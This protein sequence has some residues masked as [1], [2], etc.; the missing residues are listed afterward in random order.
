MLLVLRLLSQTSDDTDRLLTWKDAPDAMDFDE[1]KKNYNERVGGRRNTNIYSEICEGLKSGNIDQMMKW[2]KVTGLLI[3]M[4]EPLPKSTTV[5]CLSIHQ[6]WEVLDHYKQLIAGH[7]IGI[8]SPLSSTCIDPRSAPSTL[9]LIL[10]NVSEG[11]KIAPLSQYPGES[12]IIIPPF[13]IYKVSDCQQ[14]AFGCSVTASS[15]SLLGSYS[16]EVVEF[17]KTAT[18]DLHSAEARLTRIKEM[19][20]VHEQ[21]KVL[22]DKNAQT[23]GIRKVKKDLNG[24]TN[25]EISKQ[26]WEERENWNTQREGVLS[27]CWSEMSRQEENLMKKQAVIQGNA[28]DHPPSLSNMAPTTPTLTAKQRTMEREYQ[29]RVDTQLSYNSFRTPRQ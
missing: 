4:S 17:K 19:L 23:F 3:S 28:F 6:P 2:C 7:V 25:F 27:R 10:H 1:V 8:E 15:M 14:T 18:E 12:E 20:A 16:P 22:P 13:S 29:M 26:M 11:L 24:T 9:R 21:L 5:Q